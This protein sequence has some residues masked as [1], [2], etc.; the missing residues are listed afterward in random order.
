MKEERVS[1]YR[2][3]MSFA[4]TPS[5]QPECAQNGESVSSLVTGKLLGLE[6]T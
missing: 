2:T 1:L 5:D 4:N 3:Y 6:E